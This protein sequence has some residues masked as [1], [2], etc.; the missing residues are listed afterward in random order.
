MNKYLPLKRQALVLFFLLTI[1]N[2]A[3]GQEKNILYDEIQHHR[4]NRDFQNSSIELFRNFSF[5][6]NSK[7]RIEKMIIQPASISR[8]TSTKPQYLSVE[9]PLDKEKPS[10]SSVLLLKQRKLTNNELSI[11]IQ[12]KN[13][14]SVIAQQK[15]IAYS[16]IIE[17]E[18]KSFVSV[19]FY[20]NEMLGKIFIDDKEFTIS[21][22]KM[23][24]M[25]YELIQSSQKEMLPFPCGVRDQDIKSIVGLQSPIISKTTIP[26]CLKL[27]FEITKALN[28]EFGG[29]QASVLQFLS[30]FN[31][32]QTKF[33]NAGITVRL[34]YL[35]IWDT[36]DPYYQ[37]WYGMP[38]ASG[39]FQ[40]LGYNS[41]QQLGGTINGNIGILLSNFSSTV[42]GLAGGT[43]CPNDG[44]CTV[45]YY[46][47]SQAGSAKLIMHEIGHVLGSHHTHWCGWLGGPIDNCAT[48]EGACS[49]GPN[50]VNNGTIMSYCNSAYDNFI[51]DN[52][53]GTLPLG[54][55]QN[56]ITN[57]TC[58][59]SC[60][61]AIS[62]EDNIVNM[63][64]IA[65]TTANSFT[66]NWTSAYPVKVYFREVGVAN[67]T[68]LNTV[69]LPGSSYEISYTPA[70]NCAI[71]KF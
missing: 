29:V 51:L 50:P 60:D 58:I 71:Q 39:S 14:N 62:C 28:D 13:G 9:V 35:K 63:T 1:S 33:A 47:S 65:N 2:F 52:G 17:N 6:E 48:P 10:F 45:H 70:A 31:L 64:S 68:L 69:P 24:N 44:Y 15:Y 53:F 41:F 40:D 34:S 42:G 12:H 7:E 11:I 57:S 3:F 5:S 27:H 8:I 54:V 43:P 16:G 32:V 61:S 66:V 67:F 21:R 55:I 46:T 4:D 36:D 49:P 30:T 20:N 25:Q 56:T 59:V 23:D 37:S 26:K 22:S 38:G 19:V 18:E